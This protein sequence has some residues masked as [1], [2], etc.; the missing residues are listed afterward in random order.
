MPNPNMVLCSPDAG[1]QRRNPGFQFPRIALGSIRATW[2]FG[3]LRRK[4]PNPPYINIVGRAMRADR[5][6]GAWDAPYGKA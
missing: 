2:L 1:A 3:G 5:P 6:A 4:S